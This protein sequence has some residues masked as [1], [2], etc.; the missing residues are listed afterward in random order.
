[1]PHIPIIFA[2]AFGENETLQVM[3]S[4]LHGKENGHMP[5][6]AHNNL[7]AKYVDSCDLATEP[8]RALA[9]DVHGM[10]AM[11]LSKCKQFAAF[12]LICR[13]RT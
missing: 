9:E 11:S 12:A 13:N 1:M 10:T 7:V 4:V 5:G 3:G 8:A 2:P 6:T